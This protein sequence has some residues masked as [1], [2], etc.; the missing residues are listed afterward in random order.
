MASLQRLLRRAAANVDYIPMVEE[1]AVY[2]A[3]TERAVRDVQRAAGLEI[4][5]VTGP[6]TWAAIAAL[7]QGS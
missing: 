2:D 3:A 6:L 4:T 1:T 5:G 7:A